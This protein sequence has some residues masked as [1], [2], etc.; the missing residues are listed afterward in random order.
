MKFY[1]KFGL[2]GQKGSIYD[3]YNPGKALDMV[4]TVRECLGK[5]KFPVEKIE[6]GSCHMTNDNFEIVLDSS[7]QD[8]IDA[9]ER[10]FQVKNTVNVTVPVGHLSR[11]MTMDLRI[12][13]KNTSTS[14]L[15]VIGFL[16]VTAAFFTRIKPICPI[17]RVY[18]DYAVSKDDLLEMWVADGCPTYWGIT[19]AEH[20]KTLSDAAAKRRVKEKAEIEMNV[21][22]ELVRQEEVKQAERLHE[23]MASENTKN[24][25]LKKLKDLTAQMSGLLVYVK[26]HYSLG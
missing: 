23:E 24:A 15:G 22:A 7:R 26:E 8:V 6:E 25:E 5:P 13:R 17:N 21:A 9:A 11:F 4:E 14:N 16:G 3:N 1:V 12:E 2:K 20:T 18:A 19:E 10:H